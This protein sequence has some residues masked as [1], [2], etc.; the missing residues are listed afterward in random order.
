MAFTVPPYVYEIFDHEYRRPEWFGTPTTVA[1]GWFD[2]QRTVTAWFDDELIN[3]AEIV[4]KQLATL[5][6]PFVDDDDV[7]FK[8]EGENGE[9]LI[10]VIVFPAMFDDED[11]IFSPV[12]IR[13][14]E[15][16][17]RYLKNEI[18]RTR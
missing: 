15:P 7:I 10:T 18:I 14:L 6:A 4:P 2:A 11:L 3:G 5:W 8:M 9:S 17:D 13:K 12:A 1:A 16:P